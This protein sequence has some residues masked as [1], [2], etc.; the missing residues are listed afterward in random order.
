MVEEEEKAEEED[1]IEEGE[2]VQEDCSNAECV[3]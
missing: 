2:M 3:L 1:T